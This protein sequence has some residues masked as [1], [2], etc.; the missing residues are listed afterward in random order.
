MKK[1]NF[2][3]IINSR[4]PLPKYN[5][6]SNEFKMTKT[7]NRSKTLGVKLQTKVQ[8]SKPISIQACIEMMEQEIS[9]RQK[10]EI[11]DCIPFLSSLKFFNDYILY[12]E[13]KE[14]YL[15]LL[16]K[17]A[18]V[19]FYQKFKKNTI[20]K[21]I[22]EKSEYFF[23]L[24]SGSI[25]K[26]I[27]VFYK[28]KVT[29]EEYLIILMKMKILK[30]TELLKKCRQI[31]K[32]ILDIN[33]DKLEH[34]CEKTKKYNYHEILKKAKKELINLGFNIHVKSNEDYELPSIDS[35]L[36]VNL[37]LKDIKTQSNM[38]SPAKIFLYIPKYEKV[39][40]LQKGDYINYLNFN[41]FSENYTY[42]CKED[43][44]IAYLNKKETKDS[45][46]LN[47]MDNKFKNIFKTEKY[48]YYIFKDIDNNT[49]CE[50][51]ANFLNFR[52]FKRGDKIFTQGSVYEGVYL[53]NSGQIQLS[54]ISKIKNLGKLMLEILVSL[55]GIPELVAPSEI[56]KIAKKEENKLSH[57]SFNFKNVNFSTD[58]EEN[59][60]NVGC[61]KDGDILGL[62]ELYNYK[63]FLFNFTA[64]CISDEVTVF[65]INKKDFNAML[66]KEKSLYD[67]VIQKVEMRIKFMIGTIKNFKE[68]VKN[69]KNKNFSKNITLDENEVSI[70][71]NDSKQNNYSKLKT[72]N[73]EKKNKINWSS[74]ESSIAQ[75]SPTNRELCVKITENKNVFYSF[76]KN[77]RNENL[78]NFN[79]FN[80]NTIDPNI[81]QKND[82]EFLNNNL[83]FNTKF[84]SNFGNKFLN[85][86]LPSL[87]K[88]IN[89]KEIINNFNKN[90]NFESNFYIK[91]VSPL[92]SN[93]KKYYAASVKRSHKI[94]DNPIKLSYN[95]ITTNT[96]PNKIFEKIQNNLSSDSETLKKHNFLQNNN[97]SHNFP[98][99]YKSIFEVPSK[100]NKFSKAFISNK[101]NITSL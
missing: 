79:Q 75:L 65:F 89:L 39:S 51:Y 93:L 52:K 3:D 83:Y 82:D 78:L 8:K 16:S 20:I 38:N 18:W 96:S 21:R 19:L 5:S 29:L 10:E 95:R 40:T 45:E 53:I 59:L 36:N 35:Y 91:N 58:E 98:I 14:S 69:N 46:I 44:D 43:C 25:E 6:N 32:N 86:K 17:I 11:D 90:L 63:T 48:N 49:F 47:L 61:L 73:S 23:L 41:T 31:N 15:F 68:G 97:D 67:S 101:Y 27:L 50:N 70:Y 26:V 56:Q 64:E 71:V 62:N 13:T 9:H 92:K 55:K 24:M 99:L 30:E 81:T 37:I 74:A 85:K 7:F 88:K 80:K 94:I 66:S 84:D 60:I 22:G 76:T 100:P 28:E 12:K 33:Y 77:K 1:I 2:I 34:F 4:I 87:K 54:T 57:S 42:I 72:F